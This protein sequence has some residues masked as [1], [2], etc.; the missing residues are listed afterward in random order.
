MVKILL[1]TILLAWTQLVERA[2]VVSDANCDR[3]KVS[4]KVTNAENGKPNGSAEAKV[5][6]AVSPV[7]Y[8]FFLPDGRLLKKDLDVMS[9]KIE[10]LKPGKYFC[11]VADGAGCTKKVDFIIE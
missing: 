8:I 10:N 6:G 4:I 7:Y 3:L 9:N 11:S 1:V 5:E 2:P